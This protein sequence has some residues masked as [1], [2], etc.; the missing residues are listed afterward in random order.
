MNRKIST[1][2]S[3]AIIIT[4][5]ITVIVFWLINV[6]DMSFVRQ[7][8]YAKSNNVDDANT[9]ILQN[10]HTTESFI[11]NPNYKNCEDYKSALKKYGQVFQEDV[12]IIKIIGDRS[13]IKGRACRIT[14]NTKFLTNQKTNNDVT[15]IIE[16]KGWNTDIDIAADGITGNYMGYWKNSEF[17]LYEYSFEPKAS[18]G[19]DSDMA[20][21]RREN[22][23]L[24]PGGC[25]KDNELQTV[26]SLSFGSK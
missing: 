15:E 13:S 20:L 19:W 23:N 17:L 4:F 6:K 24:P 12:D 16:D 5:T 3:F 18:G 10:N 9:K 22:C 2:F 14:V 21:K 8:K 26:L 1:G 11:L 25:F 7:Q